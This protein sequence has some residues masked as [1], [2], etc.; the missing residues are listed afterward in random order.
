MVTAKYIEKQ[1]KDLGFNIHRW[2]KS[3]VQELQHIILP[4]EKIYE[5]VNGLYEGGF[6]L[7]LATDT[8]VLLVDK[9]PLNYLTVEDMRYELISEIDYNHRLIGAYIMISS[10]NKNLKF[11]TLNQPR[12]RKLIGH[13]QYCMAMAKKHENSHH[14]GQN[15]R[16]EQINRQLRSYLL[17]QHEQQEKLQE[18]LKSLQF[19]RGVAES[20]EEVI[21][22][23]VKPAPELADYLYAQGLLDK[24]RTIRGEDL[25]SP[26]IAP[27]IMA[28]AP[29][30]GPRAGS[31]RDEMAELYAE[32]M[33]EIFGRRAKAASGIAQLQS[34][35]V[36]DAATTVIADGDEGQGVNPLTIAYSRLPM[37]LR[38]R[39]F[40]RPS[41]HA[42]SQ[43]LPAAV[44]PIEVEPALD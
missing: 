7:I 13:V 43:H 36:S 34:S 44:P 18:H 30:L 35:G 22:Q 29:A 24:D 39:K 31:D 12:L 9:K 32:G 15:K 27:A 14:E 23:P 1:L 5:A 19:N 16:L 2:G 10:G 17:A 26:D 8:R 37:A 11:S 6:A 20:V 25:Q 33:Q 21:Q 41:F 42:H 4:G 3:E 38:N 40:G 28:P